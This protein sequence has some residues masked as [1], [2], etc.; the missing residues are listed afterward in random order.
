MMTNMMILE[1][2]N[3]KVIF[4]LYILMS[5]QYTTS[6][7]RWNDM[8]AYWGETLRSQLHDVTKHDVPKS[9]GFSLAAGIR[10]MQI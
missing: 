2:K 10:L 4:V 1:V 5:G 6:I 7:K 9:L 8:C 3:L